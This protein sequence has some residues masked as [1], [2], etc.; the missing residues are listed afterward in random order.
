MTLQQALPYLY[1]GIR[2]DLSTSYPQDTTNPVTAEDTK[3]YLHGSAAASVQSDGDTELGFAQRVTTDT[4]AVSQVRFSF[5]WNKRQ[6]QMNQGIG[7]AARVVLQ[8][9]D[10][11]GDL[12]APGP[13]RQTGTYGTPRSLATLFEFYTLYIWARDASDPSH[14]AQFIATR[15]LYNLVHAAAYRYA[16]GSGPQ[17]KAI[18]LKQKWVQAPGNAERL[19]G[20]ELEVVGTVESVLPDVAITTVPAPDTIL[21]PVVNG[22]NPERVFNS[23]FGGAFG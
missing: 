3:V 21:H 10:P 4:V 1:D 16:R 12:G 9:G 6:Q 11:L 17:G 20:M 15:N 5:G 19:F 2:S 13:A 14:E 7:R 23:V 8:P 22:C 18:F